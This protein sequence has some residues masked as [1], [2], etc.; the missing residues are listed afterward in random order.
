[1]KVHCDEGVAIRIG[2]RAVRRHPRG[3]RR[4]VGRGTCRPAIEP[5][6]NIVPDADAVSAAEGNMGRRVLRVPS[7]SGVVVDPGMYGSSLYGNREISGSA[8][9][10][11]EGMVRSGKARSRSR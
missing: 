3:C 4:S 2:P 10:S 5:R 11:L 1:V 6:K 7:R 8:M 9:T